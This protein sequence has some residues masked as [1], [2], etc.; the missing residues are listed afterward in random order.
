MRGAQ[1]TGQERTRSAA[2]TYFC[3]P[4]RTG[5]GNS[6]QRSVGVSAMDGFA[7]GVASTDAARLVV[8]SAY[9]IGQLKF[10]GG[11]SKS[12]RHIIVIV[13]G[14]RRSTELMCPQP[15]LKLSIKRR[16]ACA[17]SGSSSIGA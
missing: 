9:T 14:A 3:D 6:P 16:I 5:R 7:V 15:L 12:I 8:A 2:V 17:A 13:V 10:S 1:R 11:S 4:G